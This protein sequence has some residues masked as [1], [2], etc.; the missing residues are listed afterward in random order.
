M[1]TLTC[2]SCDG[3]LNCING[4]WCKP[5]KMYI[6][7]ATS[8]P[9]EKR[10][11]MPT[12]TEE[13]TEVENPDVLL[14]LQQE[15]KAEKSQYN[16][17]GHYKY[18]SAEDIL[19]ALKPLLRKY[20]AKLIIDDDVQLIGQRYYIKS[21]ARIILPD[22]ECFEANGWARE[23]DSKKGMDSPQLSSATASYAHK[24]ALG[25]LFCIDDTKDSDAT[26]HSAAEVDVAGAIAQLNAAKTMTELANIWTTNKQ[27]QHDTQFQKAK[28][29]N[30]QRLSA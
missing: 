5:M 24:I 7:Y 19:K 18:R 2:K 16:S 15:L 28:N 27:F 13:K 11:Y 12:K 10:F 21:T 3:A 17:F 8:E 23:D 30:K 22:L 26:S 25:N 9:C 6:E 14:S 1:T 20:G 4:R 29:D